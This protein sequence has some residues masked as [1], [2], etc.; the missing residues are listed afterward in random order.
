M[1]TKE[2]PLD[3]PY[4]YACT[5]CGATWMLGKELRTG[6]CAHRGKVV[7]RRNTAFCGKRI[8]NCDTGAPECGGPCHLNAGHSGQCECIADLPGQPGSCGA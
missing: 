5:G 6:S 3:A 7:E 2:T 4:Y 8:Q 1:A